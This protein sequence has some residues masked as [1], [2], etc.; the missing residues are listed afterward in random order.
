MLREAG[1]RHPPRHQGARLADPDNDAEFFYLRPRDIAVYV[2]SGTV[3]VGVTGRDLLLDSA[4]RDRGHGPRLRRLDFRYAARPGNGRASRL[5]GSAWRP[6][7]RASSCATSPSAASRPRSSASTV[8]RDGDHPGRRRRHRRRRRDRHHLRSQG[9]EV[10]GEPILRSEAVLIRGDGAGEQHDGP[11]VLR[12]RLPGVITART[13][14]MLDYD[15]PGTRRQGRRSPRPRVPD[16]LA[17]AGRAGAR[18]GRWCRARP[19]RV[20]D[21]LYDLGARAILV[22]DIARVPAVSGP[23][24]TRTGFSWSSA[25]RRCGRSAPAGPA[26]GD[27]MAVGVAARL[28]RHRRPAAHDAGRRL[29]TGRPLL[30]AGL[31]VL[32]ALACWRYATIRAVPSLDG[33]VVRNLVV[34]RT[35]PGPRSST[36]SSAGESRG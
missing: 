1:Y 33:L 34:T 32:I 12:R 9:L 6:A 16:G 28:R 3:D 22:T 24:P 19:N 2:G 14:V 8:R 21:E 35:S 13:Y 18:S 36:W 5:A 17:A 27:R 26:R 11:P 20:M 10:F 31:G 23:A 30:V 25:A 7:T 15:C 29:A 4:R